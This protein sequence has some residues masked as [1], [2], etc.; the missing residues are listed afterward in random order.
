MAQN[1]D[2]FKGEVKESAGRLT[3]NEGLEREGKLDQ[4]Q[5]KIDEAIDDFT[6]KIRNLVGG[7]S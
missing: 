1:W 7:S 3:H 2:D 6:D 5:G 4:L